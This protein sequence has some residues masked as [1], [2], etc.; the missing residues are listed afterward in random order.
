MA[1]ALLRT[2][3]DLTDREVLVVGAGAAS[4]SRIAGLRAAGARVVVVTGLADATSAVAG[5]A[6]GAADHPEPE[7][8]AG[9]GVSDAV[10]DLADRGAITLYRRPA[11]PT[12]FERAWLV[13]PATG[14]PDVDAAVAAQADQH[15]RLTLPAVTGSDQFS[16]SPAAAEQPGSEESG[17]GRSVSGEWASGEW[18]SK[19]AASPRPG[20]DPAASP[21]G[22]AGGAGPGEGP[23]IAGSPR[24]GRVVLVG[25][26]PGDPDLITVAGR[27]AV[28]RADV[29]VTDRLAPLALLAEVRPGT[30]IV[31]V[32]KVPAGPTTGQDE[33]NRILVDRARAGRNVVRLKGGDGFVFGRGAEE[34]Q[35]CVAAGIAVDVIPGLSSAVAVPGLA[36]IPLTHRDL[37][38]GFTVVSGHVPPG[39][40]RSILDWAALA[41]TGTALVVLMGVRTLPAITRTLIEHGL[42]A[43]TPAA[44]IADGGLPGQRVVRAPLD[45]IAEAGSRAGIS[46]PAITVIGTVAAFDPSVG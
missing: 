18:V 27:R 42:P 38:Q 41:R 10:T 19:P 11:G 40:R 16:S 44:T 5:L 4:L 26:G 1:A 2:E 6:D 35:A 37:N 15:H 14:R 21:P 34:W 45:R 7:P 28:R 36:G 22:P 39:D 29:V 12:D 25:G 24:P 32:S 30:E 43:D 3:L 31:D 23:S 17:S 33:I 9:T 13:A 46:P 20:T 8:P